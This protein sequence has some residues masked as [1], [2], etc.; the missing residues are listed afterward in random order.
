MQHPDSVPR[1]PDQATDDP[2]SGTTDIPSSAIADGG[3]GGVPLPGAAHKPKRRRSQ[4]E[5]LELAAAFRASG[6]SLESF[7]ALHEVEESTVL[8]WLRFAD[9]DKRPGRAERPRFTPEERRAAV[10]EF[11]KSGR[12]R[13]GFA[14]LWGCSPSSLVKWAKRYH[15]E[16]P[17]SLEDKP[18]PK[19]RRPHHPRR[20]PDMVRQA[21][22][23]IRQQHPD[24]G[25][26]SVA[27]HL[28]RFH[29]IEVSSSSVRNILLE[30]GI[31]MQ[32]AP[33]KR[34]RPKSKLPRRFERAKPG[35]MWQ[36]DIT[37]FVLRRH[38]RRVYLTVFLDD[39]SRY[40]VAWA[41]ATHQRT[42]L[43]T[44]PLLEGISRYGKPREVLTDQGRQY[45]AWRGKS[46]FSK[47]LAKEG[48]QHVVSRT[49][50]PQTLGKCERLWKTVGN[51]FW[52]RAKPQDL[53]DARERLGHYF[54]HYNFH[55]PHQGIDGR[56]PADRFFEAE[57]ALR[58][59]LQAQA[60]AHALSDALHERARKPLYLFGRVG[61]EQFAMHGERGRVVYDAPDGTRHELELDELG[62]R[63]SST[64]ST[65]VPNETSND[66][67]PQTEPA[68][69]RTDAETETHADVA[70]ANGV[71]QS[72]ASGVERARALGECAEGAEG[73]GACDVHDDPVVLDGEDDEAGCGE[74]AGGDALAGVA[75]EPVGAV[76]D[77]GGAVASAANACAEG[78]FR[79]EADGV[80]GELGETRAAPGGGAVEDRRP[81]AGPEIGPVERREHRIDLDRRK[82]SCPEE[83]TS[84][85]EEGRRTPNEP[86]SEPRSD[87]RGRRGRSW[88]R[89]LR[90]SK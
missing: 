70:Q 18:H 28:A 59:S 73:R 17:K 27:Q 29:G 8:A 75:A 77:A 20:L 25:V 40:V 47:L 79:G 68:L 64:P 14:R 45:F 39:H 71:S 81:G 23:E 67:N 46:G 48:I 58:Q 57:S 42:P 65:S 62:S 38:G 2:G 72:A 83:E 60:S 50:H 66:R 82:D 7:A 10:E 15:A 54:T 21:I 51:E 43:V 56:V 87:S 32:P 52:D 1:V 12:S 19:G 53:D 78:G 90:S 44:E 80:A 76:G 41:L 63:S 4:Q 5:R 85:E 31:A 33:A 11:E 61:D 84:A 34:R 6:S 55:R 88:W 13:N 37:S 30:A 74:A 3:M 35:E 49:H 9:K 22:I 24:F 69:A 26:N 36:S 16:G 86:G 89:W